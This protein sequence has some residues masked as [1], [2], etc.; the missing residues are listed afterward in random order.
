MRYSNDQ[1]EEPA[2]NFKFA[3]KEEMKTIYICVQ[4]ILNQSETK[5]ELKNK[6]KT[7]S[8]VNINVS[9]LPCTMIEKL[10]MYTEKK[11][12]M[13]KSM[14]TTFCGYNEN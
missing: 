8:K 9:L 13:L 12:R 4:K 10:E 14:R 2:E 6:L 5:R 3:K 7:V 1:K 11:K